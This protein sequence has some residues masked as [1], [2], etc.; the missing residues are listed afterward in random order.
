MPKW[1]ETTLSV[2]LTAAAITIATTLVVRELRVASQ[3]SASQQPRENVYHPNWR[4]YLDSGV[5]IGR[6]DAPVQLIE[7]A[8]LECPFCRQFHV[9]A[10]AE[11][12]ASYH[13]AI[14]V[15][16]V[17]F[18]LR[19]HRF[20]SMAAHAAQCAAESARFEAFVGAVYA[21]QDS[22]G[23]KDWSSFAVDA[24]VADMPG[25]LTCLDDPATA[26]RVQAGRQ[27]GDSLGITGTPT[28]LLNGWQL[29]ATPS[30]AQ[31]STMIDRILVG[32]SPV[33]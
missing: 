6:A 16:Y 13:D 26:V 11:I 15:T 24:G 12:R 7:F 28:F 5:R 31:L 19:M 9:G 25:F 20:A 30:A 22:L 21:N 14:A 18:P 32:D 29:A 4:N 2:S 3:A 1:L 27:L 23:L 33:K 8:D 17:H 10:L